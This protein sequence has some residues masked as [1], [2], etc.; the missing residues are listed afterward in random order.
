MQDMYA[1][2]LLPLPINRLF[3]YK[4]PEFLLSKVQKGAR[5]VIPFKHNIRVGLVWKYPVD[6][7]VETV[8]TIWYIIDN[9]PIIDEK[10]CAFYEE[11]SQY[12]MIPLG[13]ILHSAWPRAL[14]STQGLYFSSTA[15]R[16]SLLPSALRHVLSENMYCKYQYIRKNIDISTKDFEYFIETESISINMKFRMPQYIT[17]FEGID[18]QKVTQS[19]RST[20]QKALINKYLNHTEDVCAVDDLVSDKGS[21]V[22]LRML[23]KKKIWKEATQIISSNRVQE[24]LLPTASFISPGQRITLWRTT[25]SEAL[26]TLRPWLHS[27]VE[28]KRY[29]LWLLPTYSILQKRMSALQD[30]PITSFDHSLSPMVQKKIWKDILLGKYFIILGLRKSLFLPISKLD[31]IITEEGA[32]ELSIPKDLSFSLKHGALIRGKVQSNHVILLNPAP[33]L[34]SMYKSWQGKYFTPTT[35]L[36]STHANI[37]ILL[38]HNTNIQN[39]VKSI[40]DN[41]KQILIFYPQKGYGRYLQCQNCGKACI[42]SMCGLTFRVNKHEL[43]CG[44]CGN[45]QDTAICCTFCKEQNLKVEGEGTLSIEERLSAAFPSYRIERWEGKDVHAKQASYIQ[46]NFLKKK[47]IN[48]LIA[49]AH[50][51]NEWDK[52]F[53]GIVLFWEVDHW[54]HRPDFRA[55]ANFVQW[56]ELIR[57]QTN[58]KKTKILLYTK[59][60]STKKNLLQLFSGGYDAFMRREAHERKHFKYPPYVRLITLLIRHQSAKYIQEQVKEMVQILDKAPLATPLQFSPIVYS[61][62][63]KKFS[64]KIFCKIF[65]KTTYQKVIQSILK[66][67]LAKTQLIYRIYID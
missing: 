25:F 53:Q 10:T 49:T 61:A 37:E 65:L 50:N 63:D 62:L 1:Q 51:I 39:I 8:Y 67:W 57:K 60:K 64:Q 41:H 30:L 32:N 9:Q 28:R 35:L 52:N 56:V 11:L 22:A 29:I 45:R 4:V 40:L 23:L 31:C 58:E 47:T 19:L 12:Y 48:I 66:D 21:R 42:C 34:E 18:K 38:E 55:Q 7:D 3:T 15:S 26:D 36:P 2:V 33:S 17:W 54:L 59:Y 44:N 24:S 20:H 16:E 13:K 5:V 14:A 27:C 46:Q 6:K 43:Y